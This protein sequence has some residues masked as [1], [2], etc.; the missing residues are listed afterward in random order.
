LALA[1]VVMTL[2]A[3][4]S[5]GVSAQQNQMSF[6]VTSAGSGNGANLGGLAGG[7]RSVRPWLLRQVRAAAV[8]RVSQRCG[9]S[10]TAGGQREGSDR[11]GAVE[12]VE[13]RGDSQ[14]RC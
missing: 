6:F 11:Q 4:A 7:T 5:F 14:Q 13:G 12:N 9:R 2:T 8:A 10:G 1:I 3:L